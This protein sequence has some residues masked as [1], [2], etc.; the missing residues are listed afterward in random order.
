MGYDSIPQEVTHDDRLGLA[1]VA[2]IRAARIN[3]K[4]NPYYL[5]TDEWTAYESGWRDQLARH[6]RVLR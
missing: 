2:G 5:A 4:A 1:Y 6:P 3:T